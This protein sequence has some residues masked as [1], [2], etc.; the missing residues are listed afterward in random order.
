[1]LTNVSQPQTLNLSRLAD[2]SE[3]AGQG[4]FFYTFFTWE[5]PL[6]GE[7]RIDLVTRSL[8]DNK[9]FLFKHLTTFDHA[10]V[11]ILYGQIKFCTGT[12]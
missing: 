2:D 4:F 5:T 10:F 11:V 12:S 1:M 6:V 8:T 9:Q 3:R 7:T